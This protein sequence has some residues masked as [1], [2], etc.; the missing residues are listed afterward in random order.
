MKA[1]VT[2]A[3]SGIGKDMAKELAKKGYNLVLVAR[4]E[5]ELQKQLIMLV[6]EIVVIFQ[7]LHWIKRLP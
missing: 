2:G 5:E 1:L 3:S 7:K 6:L 4:N